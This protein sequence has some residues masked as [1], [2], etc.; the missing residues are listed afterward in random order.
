MILEIIYIYFAPI[1]ILNTDFSSN[2]TCLVLL[3]IR[4]RICV[5]IFEAFT[6]LRLILKNHLHIHSY[7]GQDMLLKILY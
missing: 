6:F 2:R 3:S 7:F 5:N 4:I 1:L